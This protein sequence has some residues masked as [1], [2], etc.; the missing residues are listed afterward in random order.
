MRLTRHVIRDIKTRAYFRA[1]SWVDD[2]A[3]AQDFKHTRLVIEA[4][5]K[6]DLP[7]VEM[8]IQVCEKPSPKYEIIFPISG[9]GKR[10]GETRHT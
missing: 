8:V 3:L 2:P 5:A 10:R 7:E 6:Y 9:V 1:G 4:C